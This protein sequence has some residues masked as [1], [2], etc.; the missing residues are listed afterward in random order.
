[1]DLRNSAFKGDTPKRTVLIVCS[2]TLPTVGGAVRHTYRI[3]I[4]LAVQQL[5]HS[6]AAGSSYE[7][8]KKEE[9]KRD[10][11]ISFVIFVDINGPQKG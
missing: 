5:V 2:R 3:L 4:L 9:K 7:P 11:K 10:L 6:T 8:V 1:M